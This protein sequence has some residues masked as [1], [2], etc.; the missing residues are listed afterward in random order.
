MRS[1]RWSR[2]AW[3]GK[4]VTRVR[5]NS[6]TPPTRPVRERHDATV[7]SRS[8]HCCAGPAHAPN[9]HQRNAP[10]AP[11]GALSTGPGPQSPAWAVTSS[12][13]RPWPSSAPPA[14]PSPLAHLQR[15]FPPRT[16]GAS[17]FR[18]TSSVPPPRPYR[19][20]IDP[21]QPCPIAG[22]IK[23]DPRPAPL[24]SAV[25]FGKAPRVAFGVGHDLPGFCSSR[26]GGAS[27]P[28]RHST[29]QS[30][31]LLCHILCLKSS[32]QVARPGISRHLRD[33]ASRA[34]SL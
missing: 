6:T 10:P 31:T 7:Q 29:T 23:P 2:I 14:V 18:C 4:S 15:S 30:G 21:G 3:I 5:A 1:T 27:D 19:P 17:R 9:A 11:N 28:R 33:I 25:P 8:G 26:A 22:Q 13:W 34:K 16:G 24:R 12:R 32:P 20:R